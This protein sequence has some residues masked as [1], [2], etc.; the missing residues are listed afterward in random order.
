MEEVNIRNKQCATQVL[1]DQL[2]F[3]KN[4]SKCSEFDDWTELRN[5]FR[6]RILSLNGKEMN[7]T[8]NMLSG[9]M[10]LR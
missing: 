5:L 6:E 9:L 4:M 7:N 2:L 1:E 8:N 10:Y 3:F